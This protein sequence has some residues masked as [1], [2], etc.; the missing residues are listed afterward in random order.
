MELVP[1]RRKPGFL[2]RPPALERTSLKVTVLMGVRG[3]GGGGVS[4]LNLPY[5][6]V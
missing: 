3:G 2:A 6:L 5:L 1:K 4:F